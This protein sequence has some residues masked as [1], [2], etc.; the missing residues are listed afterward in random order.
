M[1]PIARCACDK[2]KL[3]HRNELSLSLSLDCCVALPLMGKSI[4]KKATK[5]FCVVAYSLC[6]VF[7]R[8]HTRT[9]SH[10]GTYNTK[11]RYIGNCLMSRINMIKSSKYQTLA[12]EIMQRQTPRHGASY[13]GYRSNANE[14]LLQMMTYIKSLWNALILLRWW[15]LHIQLICAVC[16]HIPLTFLYASARA[17][18]LNSWLW[19]RMRAPVLSANAAIPPFPSSILIKVIATTHE[20]FR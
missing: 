20:H 6:A 11:S 18:T 10:A 4:R 17:R 2:L 1:P 5:W 19:C 3:S 12:Y 8:Y 16:I 13:L 9:R 14:L 7:M 15:E